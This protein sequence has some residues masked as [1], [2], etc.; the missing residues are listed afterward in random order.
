[1]FEKDQNLKFQC[2]EKLKF[3]IPMIEKSNSNVWKKQNLEFQ[4]LEKVDI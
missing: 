3:R 4:W 2:L 1:M